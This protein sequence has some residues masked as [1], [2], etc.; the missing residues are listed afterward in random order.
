MS[1]D[2]EQDDGT[3]QTGTKGKGKVGR[4]ADGRLVGEAVPLMELFATH[5]THA[6]VHFVAE[7]FRATEPYVYLVLRILPYLLPFIAICHYFE[8]DRFESKQEDIQGF[9]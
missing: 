7:L 8:N 1:K 9:T 4:P 2:T 5:E 6:N 3:K